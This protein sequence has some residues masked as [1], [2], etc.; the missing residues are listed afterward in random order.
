MVVTLPEMLR[1]QAQLTSL[2]VGARASG[3]ARRPSAPFARLSKAADRSSSV[4]D[5]LAWA[6]ANGVEKKGMRRMPENFVFDDKGAVQSM[7]LQSSSSSLT[8]LLQLL[9]LVVAVAV[10]PRRQ[11]RAH[12]GTRR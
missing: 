4:N 10:S 7:V 11:L 6:Q 5:D 12:P 2:P 9:L 1:V 8:I 3:V